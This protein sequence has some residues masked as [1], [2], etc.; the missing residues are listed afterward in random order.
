MSQPLINVNQQGSVIEKREKLQ[1]GPLGAAFAIPVLGVVNFV[2]L[3]LLTFFNFVSGDDYKY[4]LLHLTSLVGFVF[5]IAAAR[6]VQREIEP[7]ISGRIV[8]SRFLTIAA[9]T[10]LAVYLVFGAY[11]LFREFPGS[12]SIQLKFWG[13]AMFLLGLFSLGSSV[14]L[15]LAIDGYRKAYNKSATS[16]CEKRGVRFSDHF[17]AE[18]EGAVYWGGA[19]TEE[20]EE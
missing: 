14:A 16:L 7:S 19:W 10:S 1:E 5:L 8:V 11:A 3:I 2:I 4:V 15:I 13:L 20:S 6:S 17:G 12:N 9:L 18:E